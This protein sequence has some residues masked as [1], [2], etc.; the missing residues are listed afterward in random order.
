MKIEDLMTRDVSSCRSDETA[1]RAAQ[2]MWEGDCG[3]IPVVDAEERPIG[4]I[5]DRD[6]CMAAYTQG[7]VLS[8]I[9]VHDVMSRG[10]LACGA[11]DS[12]TE[13]ET[14]MGQKRVHRLPVVDAQGRLVGILSLNDLAR[15]S[16]QVGG[17]SSEGLSYQ[18]VAQ[19]LDSICTSSCSLLVPP[20][21]EAASVAAPAREPQLASGR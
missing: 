6:I 14:A 18:D 20:T 3:A 2:L 7:R 13:A 5:T 8:D 15:R 19:T 21:Q 4:M 11:D 10:V 17:D 16:V 12:L 9:R 1:N